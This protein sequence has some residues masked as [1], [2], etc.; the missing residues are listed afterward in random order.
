MSKITLIHGSCAD[1]KADAVVCAYSS[2]QM[3]EARLEFDSCI[4]G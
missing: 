2:E 1:Q 3:R 4:Q